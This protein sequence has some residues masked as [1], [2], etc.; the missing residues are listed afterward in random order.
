MYYRKGNANRS[1][2]ILEL[3]RNV[4]LTAESIYM[5]QKVQ[6][7]PKIVVRKSDQVDSWTSPSLVLLSGGYEKC[8]YWVRSEV[9]MEV[10]RPRVHC[11]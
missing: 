3:T 1:K 10:G 11:G 9:E 5:F 6:N 2:F 4:E 8:W 7:V